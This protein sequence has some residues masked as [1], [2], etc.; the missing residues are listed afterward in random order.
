MTAAVFGFRLERPLANADLPTASIS[1]WWEVSREQ[2][3]EAH[4]GPCHFQLSQTARSADN[5]LRERAV[6]KAILVVIIEA[7]IPG[8]TDNP[9]HRDE[10]V[11]RA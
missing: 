3:R 2:P 8:N 5:G 6:A 4:V 9:R 10:E 11:E 7:K 1:L